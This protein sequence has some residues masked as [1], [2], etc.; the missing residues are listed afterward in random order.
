MS[1]HARLIARNPGGQEFC[2]WLEAMPC[3]QNV[4]QDFLLSSSLLYFVLKIVMVTTLSLCENSNVDA[5]SNSQLSDF[6]YTEDIV[7]LNKDPGKFDA[8]IYRVD[9]SAAELVIFLATTKCKILFQGWI[10]TKLNL[11]LGEGY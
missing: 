11:A 8:F 1:H 7:L 6:E 2:R 3:R 9:D 10:G 5:C 4:C